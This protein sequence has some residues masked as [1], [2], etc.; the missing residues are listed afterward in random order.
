LAE[1]LRS[2]SLVVISH[3]HEGEPSY[4]IGRVLSINSR[5]AC[6]NLSRTTDSVYPLSAITAV[7][8]AAKESQ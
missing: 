2:R 5:H 4:A 8:P 7:E 3:T 6:I 1:A